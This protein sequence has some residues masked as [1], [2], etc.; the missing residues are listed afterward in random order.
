[1]RQYY[2]VRVYGVTLGGAKYSESEPVTFEVATKI[3]GDAERIGHRAD[4]LKCAPPQSPGKKR[5]VEQLPLLE[6][7]WFSEGKGAP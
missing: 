5:T 6:A 4:V 2:K 3:R 7:K 1:V